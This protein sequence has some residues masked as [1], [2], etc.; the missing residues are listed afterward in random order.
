VASRVTRSPS[1]PLSSRRR[2]AVTGAAGFVGSTLVD[3]LLADGHD[4]VGVDSFSPFY[5]R[6]F[7][8]R[9]LEE[10]TRSERFEL[11]ELDLRHAE[12]GSWLQ[13]LDGVFHLAAQP[14]VVT[15]WGDA[16][17]AYVSNNVLA[18]QR[19]LEASVRVGLPRLV[20]ASSSSVYGE[21]VP[22]PMHESARCTPFSPYGVTKL[23][24]EHLVEL[25]RA[26]HGLSSACL[27]FFT[28][29]GPRQRPD[30]AFSRFIDAMV[31]GAPL[32][33]RGDGLQTRDFTFVDDIVEGLVLAMDA[34]SEGVFNLGGGTR[35]TLLDAVALLASHLG[36]TV[37]TSPA[38]APKGDVRHTFADTSRAQRELGFA[39]RVSLEE[40]LRRQIAW[41]VRSGPG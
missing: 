9:N 2:Y 23:A 13:G 20:Y 41:R 27:R 6:A 3:R 30:M 21:G 5:G 39:P 31:G 38:E 18:T 24:G 1:P 34:T 17:D 11:L 37:D 33:L 4:V 28:V 40:G 26:N 36:V 22:L 10:A 35:A 15:S 25:Y 7:K 29:Y 8:E 19:L 12:L 16:F 14:G 32:P